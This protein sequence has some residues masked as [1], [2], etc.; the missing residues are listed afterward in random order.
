MKSAMTTD[1]G[2]KI[3]AVKYVEMYENALKARLGAELISK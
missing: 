3:S 2:W 1:F